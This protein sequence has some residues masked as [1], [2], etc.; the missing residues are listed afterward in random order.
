M[1]SRV[2]RINKTDPKILLVVWRVFAA[3]LVS[4]TISLFILFILPCLVNTQGTSAL[5][6]PIRNY[7]YSA[8]PMGLVL[9]LSLFLL[10]FAITIVTIAITIMGY[11]YRYYHL[12]HCH[13]HHCNFILPSSLSQPPIYPPTITTHQPN[14]THLPTII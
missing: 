4:C 1:Q 13:Y 9:G 12:L 8:S 10:K 5:P 11:H 2:A 6:K 14:P 3:P 7:T